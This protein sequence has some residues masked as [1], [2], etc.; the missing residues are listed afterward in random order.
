MRSS[1]SD[2][3]QK[4]SLPV[5]NKVNKVQ[6]EVR[7]LRLTYSVELRDCH[8]GRWDIE[9]IAQVVVFSDSLLLG[10]M[11]RGLVLWLT[12]GIIVTFVRAIYLIGSMPAAGLPI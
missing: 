4:T 11:S 7:K 5:G 12:S 2:L 9:K 8:C 1:N 6:R 10:L 3:E